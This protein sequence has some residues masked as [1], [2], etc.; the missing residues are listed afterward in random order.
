MND[1]FH[2]LSLGFLA[3]FAVTAMIDGVYLH[4]WRY[5]LYAR[6][7]ARLEHVIHTVRA[8]LFVPALWWV[9]VGN[10]SGGLLWLGIGAI[11]VDFVVQ[12]LDTRIEADSRSFQGGLPR[13][14]LSIHII[15]AVSHFALIVTSLLA[16]PAEAFARHVPIE[17]AVP[18]FVAESALAVFL[19][20]AVMM[21][22]LHVALLHPKVVRWAE[23]LRATREPSLQ[24]RPA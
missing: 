24:R 5:R 1:F 7:E 19:G 13:A 22:A 2:L 3:L 17:G 20:G 4:L 11:V 18:T 21:A 6:P 23:S 15:A 12:I 9:F 14:E 8:I 16:R 10:T